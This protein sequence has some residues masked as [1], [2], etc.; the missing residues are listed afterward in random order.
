VNKAYRQASAAV[1]HPVIIATDMAILIE[2]WPST[3]GM[4]ARYRPVIAHVGHAG[5]FAAEE[6]NVVAAECML[7]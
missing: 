3:M 2:R 5:A 7:V 4:S 1:L 6:K